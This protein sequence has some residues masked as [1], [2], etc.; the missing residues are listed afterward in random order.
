M[1]KLDLKKG[2]ILKLAKSFSKLC[3]V[4]VQERLAALMHVPCTS[5]SCANGTLGSRLWKVSL[6]VSS[7][8]RL[9]VVRDGR[10]RRQR[11]R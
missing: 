9:T 10:K 6:T 2:E 3:F 1:L 7:S 11:D 8:V 4:N 5:L